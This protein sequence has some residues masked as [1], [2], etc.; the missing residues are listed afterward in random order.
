M[1]DRGFREPRRRGFDDDFAPARRAPAF[2]PAPRRQPVSGPPTRATVKWYS[3]EKGFGFVVLDNGGGDA[4]LH[5][6]VV[7][8]AGS[9]ARTLQPGTAM[10][11]RVGQG[12]KGA[13]V[14]E[15]LEIEETAGPLAAVAGRPA[16]AHAVPGATRRVTGRV[17][18]YDAQRG[19]GFV[20]VEGE[21][22]DVFVHASA[23]Q[24]ARL[25]GLAE[26]QRVTLEIGQGRKGP[27]AIA[28][29]A[30]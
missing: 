27:E 28:I 17:K 20:A 23:V 8:R 24:R 9:E 1:S 22:K 13:Q 26:G 15:I 21:D 19:F 18:W 6:S 14:T 30:A 16:A 7:E 11:V 2:A 4:F 25:A 12:L 29:S 3:P 5:A 10:Q